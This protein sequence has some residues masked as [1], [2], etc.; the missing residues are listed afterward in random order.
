MC[1]RKKYPRLVVGDMI[2]ITLSWAVG[3]KRGARYSME[4]N[5]IWD[6]AFYI[7]AYHLPTASF[8]FLS[9]LTIA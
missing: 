2:I 4:E 9:T 7:K 3:R 5:I 8:N 6:T 1:E